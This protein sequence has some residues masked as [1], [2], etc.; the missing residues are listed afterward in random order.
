MARRMFGSQPTD[1]RDEV[2]LVPLLPPLEDFATDFVRL[3]SVD[4]PFL[5]VEM[6]FAF[7]AGDDRR[8][9]LEQRVA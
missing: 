6:R 2:G 8:P 9:V 5:V 7:R 1:V 4:Q 3:A